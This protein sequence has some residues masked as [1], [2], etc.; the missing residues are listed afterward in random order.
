MIRFQISIFF[1]FAFCLFGGFVS[2]LGSF[3]PT[4]CILGYIFK[5]TSL[6]ADLSS[7][8]TVACVADLHMNFRRKICKTLKNMK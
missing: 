3:T 8:K 2:W 7:L 4:V 1:F 5:I 6:S